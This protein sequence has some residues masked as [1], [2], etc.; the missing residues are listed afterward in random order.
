[1]KQAS[2]PEE[3]RTATYVS[4]PPMPSIAAS[5]LMESRQLLAL[6]QR[7]IVGLLVRS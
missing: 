7:T 5:A 3:A 4:P 1:M 6:A 2:A